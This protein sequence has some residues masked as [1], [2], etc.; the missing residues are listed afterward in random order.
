MELMQANSNNVPISEA[1]VIAKSR[2]FT[3]ELDEVE[4]ILARLEVEEHTH[5]QR[6]A[7]N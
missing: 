1:T 4:S 3:I 5:S 7:P 6:Y 2:S